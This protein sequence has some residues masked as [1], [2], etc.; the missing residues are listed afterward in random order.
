MRGAE[1]AV[2]NMEG[3]RL[4]LLVRDSRQP[5][6]EGFR[7]ILADAHGRAAHEIV[8][9][10][11][12]FGGGQLTGLGA[13]C[14]IEEVIKPQADAVRLRPYGHGSG[15]AGPYP[16][17]CRKFC[18]GTFNREFRVPQLLWLHSRIRESR[19]AGAD[20]ALRRVRC[21][22]GLTTRSGTRL[23]EASQPVTWP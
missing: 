17:T 20:R 18:R 14:S 5:P 12:P 13:G 8:I 22:D 7:H 3:A 21:R 10:K 9:V 2:C 16:A 11:E 23:F 6:V 4:P 1:K 19:L 15:P